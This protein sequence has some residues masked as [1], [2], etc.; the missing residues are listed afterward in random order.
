[1]GV[2]LQSQSFCVWLGGIGWLWTGPFLCNALS[3][4]T[5]FV[6]GHL[7]CQ[8]RFV[9]NAGS[10]H[11]YSQLLAP[12]SSLL[13]CTIASS[14]GWRGLPKCAFLEAPLLEGMLPDSPS[15]TNWCSSLQTR[16]WRYVVESTFSLVCICYSPPIVEVVALGKS[17]KAWTN[18]VHAARAL[19]S[20]VGHF[21]SATATRRNTEL[22]CW[23]TV[24]P[25]TD[26]YAKC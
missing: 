11:V 17:K 7:E 24:K 12:P 1:M 21:C 25:M 18:L 13:Q 20:K 22:L 23:R 14:T 8:H 15:W 6:S 10:G 2:S 5:P 26:A 19:G 4:G 16:V 3:S 9:P